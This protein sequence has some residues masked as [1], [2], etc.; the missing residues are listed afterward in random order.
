M[1]NSTKTDSIISALKQSQGAGVSLAEAINSLH[2]LDKVPFDDIWPAV[3]VIRQVS[4]KEALQLTK[5]WCI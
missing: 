1:W 3:M 2:N 5:E 4:E